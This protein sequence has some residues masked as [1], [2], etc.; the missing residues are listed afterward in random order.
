MVV[1]CHW[2]GD[3]YMGALY[4]FNI[5]YKSIVNMLP[6]ETFSDTICGWRFSSARRNLTGEEN[7]L[8]IC[9]AKRTVLMNIKKCDG[10][11]VS[12]IPVATLSTQDD[13]SED[14]TF[15][16]WNGGLPYQFYSC[17]ACQYVLFLSVEFYHIVIGTST[18]ERLISNGFVGYWKGLYDCALLTLQNALTLL[19]LQTIRCI[20]FA[21]ALRSQLIESYVYIQVIQ[22]KLL[23]VFMFVVPR[24]LLFYAL[25]LPRYR[26]VVDCNQAVYKLASIIQV[27]HRST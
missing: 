16:T 12:I 1:Q 18:W 7:A 4:N 11:P 21:L 10:V 20:H 13:E 25:L 23:I 22:S 6:L 15:K 19:S 24:S 8:I 3:C 5:E 17:L 9:G 27:L 2:N 26:S 14:Q